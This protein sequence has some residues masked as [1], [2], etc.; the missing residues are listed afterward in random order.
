M[1]TALSELINAYL[2]NYDV[3]KDYSRK[4]VPPAMPQHPICSAHTI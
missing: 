2:T 3:L 1:N 4:A